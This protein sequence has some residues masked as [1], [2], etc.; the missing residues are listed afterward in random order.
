MLNLVL[1]LLAG[2]VTIAAPCT[3]LIRRRV[4]GLPPW[5]ARPAV[6]PPG[7]DRGRFLSCPSPPPRWRSARSPYLRLRSRTPCA[8]P[9]PCRCLV[10]V[11][12][13]TRPKPFDGPSVRLN[14]L[15]GLKPGGQRCARQGYLGRICAGDHAWLGLDALRRPGAGLDPD[16]GRNLQQQGMGQLAA[17][18]DP[19]YMCRD[20]DAGDRLWRPGCHHAGPQHR[21]DLPNCS[22][23]SASS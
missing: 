14:G 2:V 17:G 3:P 18:R 21:G 11:S 9:R 12:G 15:M 6:R 20:S 13:R 22:R 4:P 16:G 5:S 19:R 10:L 1:A 7:D 23:G 8:P